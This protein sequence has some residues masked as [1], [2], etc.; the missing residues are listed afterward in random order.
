MDCGG[1][2]WAPN[3]ASGMVFTFTSGEGSAC[4]WDQVPWLSPA[5]T[6]VNVPNSAEKTIDVTFDA[7][8][9]APG[10]YSA[11]LHVFGVTPYQDV[12][13][14]VEMTVTPGQVF[15]PLIQR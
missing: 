12:Y 7:A 10:T 9:L 5:A 6:S 3:Q 14:P 15:V 11:H 13:V 4:G 2:L 8:G 1:A